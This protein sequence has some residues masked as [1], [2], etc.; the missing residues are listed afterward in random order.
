[1]LNVDVWSAVAQR[2]VCFFAEVGRLGRSSSAAG[3]RQVATGDVQRQSSQPAR[4]ALNQVKI[5]YCYR[6]I[7]RLV[8]MLKN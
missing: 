2:N 6:F 5:M 8:N 7:G 4:E 3:M 1:M